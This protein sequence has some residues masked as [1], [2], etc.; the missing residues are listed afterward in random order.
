MSINDS[1]RTEIW[2]NL[3]DV[4][5]YCRY[6]EVVHSQAARYHIWIRGLSLLAIVL[7]ATPF[8]DIFSGGEFAR[9]GFF[10]LATGLTVWDAVKNY[11]KQAAAAQFIYAGCDR[12]R[13][14]WTDLWISVESSIIDPS[15]AQ[16]RLREL[17]RQMSE[18]T[19]QA[20][21]NDILVDKRTNQRITDAAYNMVNKRFGKTTHSTTA[22]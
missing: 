16:H 18:I 17:S 6:Y 7:G 2:H 3:L 10:G 5:R 1:L 13:I 21:P 20:G 9:I 14:E 15:D 8:T 19:G 4:D 12:L 11:S 22:T